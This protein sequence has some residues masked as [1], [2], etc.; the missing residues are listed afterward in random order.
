MTTTSAPATTSLPRLRAAAILIAATAVAVAV[1]AVVAV[2]A[3]ALGASSSFGGLTT[4]A[5]TS[6][7]AVGMIAGWIGWRLIATRA[8]NPRR[9]LAIAVPVVLVLSF[10]PDVLLATLQF[11][12]GVTTTAVLAL[13]VMHLVVVA[14][15]VP[16]YVAAS[17]ALRR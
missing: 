6:M 4:P 7:T 16:A 8:R 3:Q 2:V 10:I 9:T 1:N 12:P 11:M 15:A 5:Y 13:M 17:R 14:I